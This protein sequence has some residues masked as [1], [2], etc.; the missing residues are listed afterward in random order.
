M[1]IENSQPPKN[2]SFSRAIFLFA[3]AFSFCASAKTQDRTCKSIPSGQEFWIRLT[4]PVSTYSSKLGA[5]VAAILIESPRC[6]DAPVFSTGT[7]VEG[8]ITYVRRVGLGF[9][10]GSSAIAINFDQLDSS[11]KSLSVDAQIEE[12]ANGREHV[13]TGVIEGVTAKETPQRLMSLR[14]LHL[15]E[16][17]PDDYWIFMLR[18]SVFPYS[19]EPETFLP[20]GTDLR[21]KLKA[22]LQLPGGFQ[23]EEEDANGGGAIDEELS[24]K[25]LALPN[26]SMTGASKPSDPVNLAFLGSPQQIE[27]AFQAAGWTYG[28]SVS[29]LSVLREMRAVSS[30]NSYSHLPISKQW[31]N[32]APPD[33]RFEKSFDSYQKREHIRI[34]N[35]DGLEEGLWAGG[36]I[37]ETGAE[38]SLRKGKFIHHVDRDVDAER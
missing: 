22:A 25:L 7:A 8:Q 29:T 12:V 18:R 13:K 26:R 10:H 16:W 14:L 32:G 27:A 1:R 17:D 30:L 4:E 3:F 34:W 19:P 6:G 37:R 23:S 35:E 36:A 5:R 15:P 2:I 9:W 38:W 33:F 20:A 11:P 24:A 31:L 21:L 28:D